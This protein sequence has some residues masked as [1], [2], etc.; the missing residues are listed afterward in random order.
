MKRLK[1]FL[2]LP[3]ADKWLLVKIGFLMGWIWL[4]LRLL[5]FQ[6]MY[7]ILAK[8]GHSN[9]IAK[10]Q[11]GQVEKICR[12]VE[13]VGGYVFGD[14]S[15]FPQALTAQLLLNRSGFH[16]CLRIGATKGNE[17]SIRAHAWVE[18]DG[19]VIVGGPISKI[20][21]YIILGDLENL[22]L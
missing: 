17:N 7:A 6:K 13:K 5:P 18:L 11:T 2:Y 10:E 22:T 19:C 4:G 16:P 9:S 14:D 8:F 12:N 3:I 20:Q 1:R 21:E 15:C